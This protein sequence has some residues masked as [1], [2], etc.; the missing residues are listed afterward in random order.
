MKKLILIMFCI[1]KFY[2]ISLQE[3]LN[4][5]KTEIINPVN[6]SIGVTSGLAMIVAYS[7][8]R[9][10]VMN[11]LEEGLEEGSNLPFNQEEK[12]ALKLI[13]EQQ[14][15]SSIQV[16][17]K[18]TTKEELRKS[19]LTFL[20][21]NKNFDKKEYPNFSELKE[22]ES[23]FLNTLEKDLREDENAYKEYLI[24][25]IWQALCHLWLIYFPIKLFCS[26]SQYSK[27]SP[28]TILAISQALTI[29]TKMMLKY[30]SKQN[31]SQWWENIDQKYV[32]FLYGFLTTAL[33]YKL[34]K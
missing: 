6:I 3:T 12:T 16:A 21:E 18:T 11:S 17:T 34:K 19:F 33:M 25:S 29:P 31:D 7:F 30:F 27:Y 8:K 2:S 26:Y 20:R 24:V 15:G 32:S 28:I 5:I 1:N 10:T 4:T 14:K 9:N 13:K 22:I 23:N